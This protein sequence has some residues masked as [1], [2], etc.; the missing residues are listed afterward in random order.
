MA[1]DRFLLRYIDKKITNSSSLNGLEV[2]CDKGY[3]LLRL[4][5]KGAVGCMAAIEIDAKWIKY[6]KTYHPVCSY[7]ISEVYKNFKTNSFD[8]IIATEILEHL[9]EL[10]AAIKKI[11]R[12]SKINADINYLCPF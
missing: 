12:V 9:T 5:E 10:G 7:F 8:F 6:A 4:Y 11:R 2:S 3:L 1:G